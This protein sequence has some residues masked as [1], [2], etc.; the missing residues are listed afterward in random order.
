MAEVQRRVL[1]DLDDGVTDA[2]F[3]RRPFAPQLLRRYETDLEPSWVEHRQ[4][5]RHLGRGPFDL[6]RE[7]RAVIAVRG[8]LARTVAPPFDASG[9]DRLLPN[10]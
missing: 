3:A 9:P 10:P 7:R 8:E 2:D 5:R 1:D 6:C 4:R